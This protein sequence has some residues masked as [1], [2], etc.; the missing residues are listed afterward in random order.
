[1]WFEQ[2]YPTND[3]IRISEGTG[4]HP[5]CVSSVAVLFKETKMCFVFYLL[6]CLNQI[7]TFPKQLDPKTHFKMKNSRWSKSIKI[8]KES[9]SQ[10][11][12]TTTLCTLWFIS[13]LL[14]VHSTFSDNPIN[15][16]D[17][18]VFIFSFFLPCNVLF[19]ILLSTSPVKCIF[20]V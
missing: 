15:T 6:W 18:L 5:H 12:I 4:S 9:K 20:C 1:M 14:V 7:Q 16:S 2:L 13:V 10:S 3:R 8:Q 17:K 19:I 11:E